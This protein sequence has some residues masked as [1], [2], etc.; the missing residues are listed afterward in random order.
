MMK[1]LQQFDEIGIKEVTVSS[2]LDKRKMDTDQ[3]QKTFNNLFDKEW[4]TK[5][6]H[7]YSL[8]E[9]GAIEAKRIVR[10]HRLWEL[11]LTQ[12]LN[13]KED[14]IH[15]TA[16]TIEHLITPELEAQLVK[17]LDYPTEDPHSKEIPYN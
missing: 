13:F 1:A 10:L 6:N 16:E 2:F 3:L 7:V 14:H 15:G 5:I 9:R 8:T 12:R 4:V 17:E 11:Y